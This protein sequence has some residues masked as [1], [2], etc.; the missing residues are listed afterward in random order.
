MLVPEPL[1]TCAV[2]LVGLPGTFGAIA[3]S[4]D[5]VISEKFVALAVP[6]MPGELLGPAGEG[7]VTETT[8]DFW[9]SA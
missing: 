7:T 8:L 2:K 4:C 9:L 6:P 3:V 1:V 5:H